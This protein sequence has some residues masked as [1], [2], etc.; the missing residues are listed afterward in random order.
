MHAN[1]LGGVHF[2]F[3]GDDE[4]HIEEIKN[5]HGY[6]VVASQI[7]MLLADDVS[8]TRANPAQRE[9]IYDATELVAIDSARVFATAVRKNA[10]SFMTLME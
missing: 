6:D 7:K 9:R 5:S 3:P 4:K 8:R 10:E 1:R 2:D